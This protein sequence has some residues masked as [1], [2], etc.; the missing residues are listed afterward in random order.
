LRHRCPH[1]AN[2]PRRQELAILAGPDGAVGLI[3]EP[4]S[5]LLL[6]ILLKKSVIPKKS[7]FW[8]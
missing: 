3:G 6:S 5:W 7:A 1:F 2:P 4:P 8:G